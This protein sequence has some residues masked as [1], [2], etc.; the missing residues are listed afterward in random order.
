MNMAELHPRPR[1]CR[2]PHSFPAP[3]TR[4]SQDSWRADLC[5]S[6][7]LPLVKLNMINAEKVLLGK[8]KTG[9]G[10]MAGP[11]RVNF[12]HVRQGQPPREY[13]EVRF[14][15]KYSTAGTRN[16]AP[17]LYDRMNTRIRTCW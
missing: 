6:G 13:S 17:P 16:E 8:T 1:A 12:D 10:G 3:L 7:L 2:P 15:Q 5:V 14:V 9:P 11:L 4:R